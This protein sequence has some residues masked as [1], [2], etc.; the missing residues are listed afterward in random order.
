MV[1]EKSTKFGDGKTLLEPPAHTNLGGAT[2]R[3]VVL[4][5]ARLTA[6]TCQQL[7][8]HLIC[9]LVSERKTDTA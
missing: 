7:I 3:L 1:V 5:P 4:I 8:S 6:P 9:M 2:L